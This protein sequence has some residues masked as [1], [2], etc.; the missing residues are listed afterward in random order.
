MAD[1]HA[2]HHDYHLVDPSPW[3]VVG[4]ISAFVM[5]VG[6]DHAGCSACMFGLP[7]AA[8]V[9]RRPRSACSTRC[10]AGGATSSSEAEHEGD[11]TRWCSSRHRYGMILFI[12]SEVM[13]FVAWFWAFFDAALFPARPCSTR[14]AEFIGGVW[15]PKGIETFDPWHLPLLNTLILLTSGTTVTWAHHALLRERPRGPEVGPVADRRCSALLFTCVQAYEYA[16]AAFGFA[17]NIYGA[18]FFMATGFHGFHVH[19]RHDLPDRLPGPRLRRAISRPSSISASK[20][21]PGT[22]TSSTWSGCSCSPAS[23]SGARGAEAWPPARTDR[24]PTCYKGRPQGRPFCFFRGAG[25]QA[26]V[27]FAVIAPT[28]IEPF[29]RGEAMTDMRRP[30]TVAQSAIARHRLP[31]PALR[32]G[33]AVSGLPRPAAA[34]RSCGLDYAFIDAGDGPAIFIM[35]LAGAIV[36]GAAPCRGNELPAAVLAARRALAA[37]DPRATLLPLRP[38]K[39]LLIALQFHHK[40]APGRLIDREPK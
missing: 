18:T 10:S 23:M 1:A 8:G 21:P 27:S 14:A 36:V 9:R 38:M 17:G 7:A 30:A 26:P 20:P 32:Q 16:H 3:P 33:Q 13:F 31:L 12:A 39:A 35:L 25:A 6:A 37:A 24:T 40:A 22:G 5:A 28:R 11:H 29:H 19:R 2:K 4:S 34:L 15:P